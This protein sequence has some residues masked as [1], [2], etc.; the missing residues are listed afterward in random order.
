MKTV[1]IAAMF[2]AVTMLFG[3]T[4]ASAYPYTTY[5]IIQLDV[6]PDDSTQSVTIDDFIEPVTPDDEIPDQMEAAIAGPII[7]GIII[8]YLL[9]K[10][11]D[12]CVSSVTGGCDCDCDS[13][14]SDSDS[15][16]DS[17]GDTGGSSEPTPDSWDSSHAYEGT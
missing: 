15:D 8:T 3:A 14:D 2:L 4:S 13:D 9:N 5:D 7:I 6:T 11:I 1:Q 10:S 17:D 16:P 12:G